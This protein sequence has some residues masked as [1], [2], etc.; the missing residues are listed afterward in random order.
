MIK[1]A[2]TFDISSFRET[3]EPIHVECSVTKQPPY[4]CSVEILDEVSA[5]EAKA[6][7]KAAK[8]SFAK[9]LA[10]YGITEYHW[11]GERV[12]PLLQLKP[13]D[14]VTHE[15]EEC[16]VV[17][18]IPQNEKCGIKRPTGQLLNNIGFSEL[19]RKKSC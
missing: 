10:D 5:R 13:G 14:K 3:A 7:K 9:E 8:V 11:K 4:E 16:E 18:I 2:F 19:L 1:K 15:G 17:Y 6:V 12:S